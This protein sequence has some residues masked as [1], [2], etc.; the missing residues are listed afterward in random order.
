VVKIDNLG[1]ESMINSKANPVFNLITTILS[2]LSSL[3]KLSLLERQKEVARKLRGVYK[4]R[5]KDTYESDEQVLMKHKR[6][7]L[8]IESK[9]I[10]KKI[11]TLTNVSPNTVKK[12]IG[13]L[14]NKQSLGGN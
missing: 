13:I 6:K 12:V 1:L 5:V 2:E 10:I 9:F 11:A 14:K 4:G 3:E 7:E 8:K